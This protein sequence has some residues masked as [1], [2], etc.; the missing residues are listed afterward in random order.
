LGIGRRRGR[1]RSRRVF[2]PRRAHGELKL[3]PSKSGSMG[4][5]P[6]ASFGGAVCLRRPFYG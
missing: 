6:F 3:S 4:P 1:R 5:E 2:D